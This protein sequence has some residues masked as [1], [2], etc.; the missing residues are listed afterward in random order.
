M[1][2]SFP[3]LSQKPKVQ[4]LIQI[5]FK[6]VGDKTQDKIKWEIHFSPSVKP[7]NQNTFVS[8]I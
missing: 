2:E 4:S 3:V 7:R 1:A 8:K 5:L 6:L